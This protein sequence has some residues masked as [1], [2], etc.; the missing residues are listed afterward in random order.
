M[1]IGYYYLYIDAM[2]MIW[3]IITFQ[4][5]IYVFACDWEIINIDVFDQNLLSI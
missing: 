5:I 4:F 3:M 2:F 1:F